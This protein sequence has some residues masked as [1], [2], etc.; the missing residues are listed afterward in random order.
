MILVLGTIGCV[1]INRCIPIEHHTNNP[2]VSV[3]HHVPRV[4]V[5]FF[6][7]TRSLR[8]TIPSIRQMI[9][10]PLHSMGFYYETFVHTFTITGT[11]RN[12]RS[13]EHCQLD[14]DEYQLLNAYKIIVEDQKAVDQNLNLPQYHHQPDPWNTAYESVDNHVRSLWSLF[15]VTKLW[16][17]E[18]TSFDY[19]IYCRPDVLYLNPLQKSFFSTLTG[20][21]IVLPDFHGHLT[22][23]VSRDLT[24][25]SFTG[26]DSWVRTNIPN[27]S[28]SMPRPFCMILFEILTFP[29]R[30]E[31]SVSGDFVPVQR[32]QSTWTSSSRKDDDRP[33]IK[34]HLSM[35]ICLIRNVTTEEDVSLW[36]NI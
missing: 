32:N 14:N 24:W 1:M 29:F 25:R 31:V 12:S 10:T 7:I 3:H 30:N 21:N 35:A 26:N 19:I 33:S 27:E 11:Y 8:H 5:C 4:A 16:E 9:F 22:D 23:S 34:H 20:S 17:Q 28:P 2:D 18:K 36:H 13:M 6:G 15:Q